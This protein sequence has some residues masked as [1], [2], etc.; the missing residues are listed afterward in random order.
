MK[1]IQPFIDL[2]W[3]TVPLKGQLIRLD[4][5]SK[6]T[7]IYEKDWKAKYQGTFNENASAIGLAITGAVS[8]IIAID[9]DSQIVYDLFR[10]Q[11]P[12]YEWIFP[13]RHKPEGGG[14]IIY[15]YQE[16]IDTFT[17]H[18]KTIQLDLFSDHGAI[19]LPTEAN[20]TKEKFPFDKFEDFPPIKEMPETI[21]ILL[22]SF[23]QQYMLGR[24]KTEDYNVLFKV[25]ANYLAPQLEIFTNDKEFSPS[26][27]RMIT[28]KSF[29]S[30]P[31]YV[32]HGYLH[33]DKVP[34]GRGSEYLTKI[35]AIFGAD[36]S[37]SKELYSKAI[38]DVNAMWAKPMP[39][40]RLVATIMEPMLSG[41]S[42][43]NGEP[44]W[45]YDEH[46]KKR[47]VTFSTKINESV[48][49]FFD[50]IRAMYYLVNYT[51]LTIKSFTRENDLFSFV[52]TIGVNVLSNKMLKQMM[53]IVRT[54]IEPALPFGFYNE[55][56][57]TRRFN[58][59]KQTP[60]L[61][62]LNNPE[63]YKDYYTTPETIL[64]YFETLIPDAYIRNYLLRFLK[65][66]FTSFKYSPVVLYLLGAHGSG[67]DTFVNILGAMI[68]DQYIAKPSA[69][70]FLEHFNGWLVDKYF[71][72][73]DEYG[74]QLSR[75]ADK[76]EALGKIKAYSGKDNIQIRQMRTDG[77]NMKHSVTFIL[78]ANTNPLLL[79]E[80]DRRIVIIDTPNILATADWV[81][82][83]GGIAKVIDG[84]FSEIQDFCYYL[85]TEVDLLSWDEYVT[86][87]K[88][89]LKDELIASVLPAAQRIAYYLKNNLIHKLEEL[90]EEYD[91]PE[92]LKYAS[93]G[94][95]FEDDLFELYF[96]MTDG[97]GTKRGLN[98][99]M[100]QNNFEKVPTTK[101]DR[102]S[103]Y[104]YINCLMSYS[105]DSVFKDYSKEKENK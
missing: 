72:Q 32:Q 69:K 38:L 21:V 88:T 94:R 49:V 1:T 62:I 45:R 74:N 26:L 25:C 97:R 51:R 13:S 6:S 80:G 68:G 33:P 60:A 5:G 47:G 16:G 7:P 87:P 61:A 41:N 70:E 28:P 18:N 57:Y 56:K 15:K 76:N 95:I 39:H 103:Y 75:T 65:R 96:E 71:V 42:N 34:E 98:K 67:K 27:F 53:P 86:P 79:E 24:G 29:R 36:P 59:F 102:K 43:I 73:L 78:T 17:I 66:K 9:C 58:L 100:A 52:S 64:N 92:V 105:K 82:E 50:D 48:E 11:D 40:S 91:K 85:A 3:H 63:T 46:W 83:Y 10:S 77:F 14:T 31:Q 22:L 30:L 20:T 101:N 54:T 12:D 104:Y 84:I 2:G 81:E 23:Q 19:Y 4:D 55:D 8:G 37:I 89:Q 93:Q 99:G 44:I 90:T 35:S